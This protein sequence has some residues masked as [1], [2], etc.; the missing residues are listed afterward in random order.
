MVNIISCEYIL[1]TCYC[2]LFLFELL[3]YFTKLK[4]CPH[5]YFILPLFWRQKNSY[6]SCN[7]WSRLYIFDHCVCM[8]VCPDSLIFQI[9]YFYC[10][11]VVYDGTRK[12]FFD[13]LVQKP[14]YREYVCLKFGL[15]YIWTILSSV[16]FGN[17]TPL[18]IIFSFLFSYLILIS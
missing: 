11:C 7:L 13:L 3:L 2:T 18:N 8:L 10:L 9:C 4:H 6:I 14:I 12:L 17:F 15:I 16:W 5:P 1:I